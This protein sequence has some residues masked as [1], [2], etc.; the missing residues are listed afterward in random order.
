MKNG[1]SFVVS[2]LMLI[3]VKKTF[4]IGGYI[5]EENYHVSADTVRTERHYCLQPREV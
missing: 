4:I 5:Y 1:K 2:K 3:F